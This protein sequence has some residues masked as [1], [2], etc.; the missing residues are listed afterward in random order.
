MSRVSFSP[1]G[2]AV[3]VL[4]LTCNQCGAPLEVPAKTRSLTCTFCAS[5]LE[6]HRSGG[7]A[8]TEVL[9]PLQ[10]RTDQVAEDMETVKLTLELEKLDRRWMQK[11]KSLVL[12]NGQVPTKDRALF[13]LWIPAI[14]GI[15]G[16][17]V[18]LGIA[19]TSADDT[20]L[21]TGIPV[22]IFW[23][24]GPIV[25]GVSLHAFLS[26]KAEAYKL[27]KQ[28][29]DR[30]RRELLQDYD[31]RRRE[32]LQDSATSS[33]RTNEKEEISWRCPSCGET[34]PASSDVCWNCGASL[35]RE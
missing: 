8:Y 18:A 19:I 12:Q 13:A 27:A 28:R 21:S 5:Q 23:G 24:I 11:R 6:V 32:L 34:V 10:Q 1:E 15:V 14:I 22:F 7:A 25:L 29:Y 17:S 35:K 26:Q 16:I 20:A 33:E 9:K 2:C 31:R 3:K 4:T 30:R